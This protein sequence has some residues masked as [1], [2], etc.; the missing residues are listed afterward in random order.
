[1]NEPHIISAVQ[2][3]TEGSL[4]PCPRCLSPAVTAEEIPINGGCNQQTRF[5]CLM[6]GFVNVIPLTL[7]RAAEVWNSAPR[8]NEI[9]PTPTTLDGAV[10]AMS[11]ALTGLV[12]SRTEKF[13]IAMLSSGRIPGWAGDIA[14]MA[15]AFARELDAQLRALENPPPDIVRPTPPDVDPPH[16]S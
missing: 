15:V 9:P 4:K 5:S 6:C 14:A 16:V 7:A 13:I 1:M 8:A 10:A 11:G 3:A 12:S 2:A